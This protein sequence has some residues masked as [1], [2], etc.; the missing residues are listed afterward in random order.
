ME[1]LSALSKL[2][3]LTLRGTQVSD[4]GL[5]HL[6]TLTNL[7]TLDLVGTRVTPRGADALQKALPKCKITL[8]AA[9]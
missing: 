2:Q 5:E 8:D 4:A 6:K 1:N 7:G 3:A 9:K